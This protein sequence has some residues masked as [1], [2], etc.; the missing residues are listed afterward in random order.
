MMREA[1]GFFYVNSWR[2]DKADHIS[3][4]KDITQRTGPRFMARE[5]I[6]VNFTLW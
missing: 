3:S 5:T 2:L 1:F 6:V 4:R